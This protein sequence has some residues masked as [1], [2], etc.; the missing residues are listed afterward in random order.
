MFLPSLPHADAWSVYN[1]NMD[2]FTHI[3]ILAE[4]L[5]S[6]GVRMTWLPDTLRLYSVLES[7]GNSVLWFVVEVLVAVF[8][9]YFFV[10][11]G[12]AV[13]REGL[14]YFKNFSNWVRVLV[15]RDVCLVLLTPGFAVSVCCSVPIFEPLVLRVCVGIPLHDAAG[16]STC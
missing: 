7:G 13:R 16:P 15:P 4:M 11:E 1:P 6:G 12:M 3:L 5:S 2:Y 8:F 10:I 14:Q 9:A